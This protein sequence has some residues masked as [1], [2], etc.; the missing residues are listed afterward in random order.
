MAKSTATLDT[1]S[2]FQS[3]AIAIYNGTQALSVINTQVE[4]LRKAEIVFGKSKKTCMYRVQF[5]DAMKAAFVGKSEKTYTNYVTAFVAA[6]NEN[7]PFSFSHSKGK[8]KGKKKSEADKTIFP[9][10]AK[11]FSHEGFATL[12][13]EIQE[14]YDNDEGSL[15]DII[16]N[17]LLADGYEI[18]E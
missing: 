6:V 18:K 11:L 10:L 15:T 13:S 3:A 4:T 16:K 5:S 1:L 8:G 17:A 9:I 14:S 7:I 12:A 2:V